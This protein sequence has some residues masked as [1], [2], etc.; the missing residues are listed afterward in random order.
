MALDSSDLNGCEK[1]LQAK[2]IRK[3]IGKHTLFLLNVCKVEKNIL[4]TFR[5]VNI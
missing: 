2:D 4:T 1:N 3:K 5:N